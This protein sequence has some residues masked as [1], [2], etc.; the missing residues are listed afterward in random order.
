[1]MQLQVTNIRFDFDGDDDITDDEKIDITD[2]ITNTIW[3]VIDEDDLV[4][5]ITCATG[6]CIESIDYRHV[7]V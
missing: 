5:E 1:M 7:L 6:W 2:E 3:D 4:E